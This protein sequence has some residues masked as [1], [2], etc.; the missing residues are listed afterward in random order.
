MKTKYLL[1]TLFL[2]L[3]LSSC[4]LMGDVDKVKPYYQLEDQNTIRDAGSAEQ[5]LRGIYTLWRSWD[6]CSFRGNMSLAAGSMSYS[7]SGSITGGNQF[8]DNNVQANN[9]VIGNFYS[10]LYAV[11]NES[12][13][14]INWLESH[15][16]KDLAPLRRQEII[17]EG[18]FHRAFAHFML[19]RHFGEFYDTKSE[20]GI[21]LSDILYLEPQAKARSSVADCYQFIEADLDSAILHAPEMPFSNYMPTHALISRTTAQALKAKVFLS[22][23]DYV[24]AAKLANEV[25]TTADAYG[26]N[27]EAYMDIFRNMYNSAEV[28]FAPYV[29]G[30]EEACDFTLD[31]IQYSPYTKSVS[32]AILPGIEIDSTGEGYDP[33]FVETLLLPKVTTSSFK[34]GKYPHS[35]NS[36]GLSNTYY[37]LRLGEVYYIHAEAEARQGGAHLAKARTSLQAVLN[38]HVPNLYNASSIPDNELLEAIRQHKWIDLVCENYEEWFDLVRYYKAG[39]VNITSVRP[40]ITTDRQLILPIP[41]DALAGNNLLIQNP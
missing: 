29:S 11:I 14:L 26:Y 36:D 20:Y 35:T 4:D 40:N 5:V 37:F 28:L 34:N 6:I 32:G 38:V 21:V 24:N 23:G 9:E 3:A 31:R 19:L 2:A 22:K 18:R 12:N 39:D 16:V 1:Y 8:L 13:F 17:A 33:R 30:Y 7:G 15:K 10:G 27:L 25:I 41:Q